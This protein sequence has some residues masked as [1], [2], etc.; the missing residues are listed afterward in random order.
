MPFHISNPVLLRL[1]EKKPLPV[2]FACRIAVVAAGVEGNRE[3][4]FFC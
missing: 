3:L 4:D 1:L 2:S